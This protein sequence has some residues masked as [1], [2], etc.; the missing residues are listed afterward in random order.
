VLD[1]V[2]AIVRQQPDD[3]E[4]F[5]EELKCGLIAKEWLTDDAYEKLAGFKALDGGRAKTDLDRDMLDDRWSILQLAVVN[6][7]SSE[8][9]K[10]G[11][12]RAF[13]RVGR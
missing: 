12:K 1:T 3:F 6:L 10:V 11:G 5:A 9:K 13:W 8:K 4:S 2:Q 7:L